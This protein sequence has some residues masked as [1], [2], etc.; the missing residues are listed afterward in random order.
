MNY[1]RNSALLPITEEESVDLM[2]PR[3]KRYTAS[4]E[5]RIILI[6]IGE[7]KV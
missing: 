2:I 6:Q 7:K 5:H 3:A 1:K 4:L